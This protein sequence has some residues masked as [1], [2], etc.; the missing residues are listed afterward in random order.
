MTLLGQTVQLLPGYKTEVTRIYYEHII[1]NTITILT[2]CRFS[3]VSL[4]DAARCISR[5][6]KKHKRDVVSQ[7]RLHKDNY[8]FHFVSIAPISS[9]RQCQPGPLQKEKTIS[10][11]PV[12]R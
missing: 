12:I 3:S 6:H 5:D 2:L 1:E 9:K 10:A 11:R 4:L 8:T 7:S